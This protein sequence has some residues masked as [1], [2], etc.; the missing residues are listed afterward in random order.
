VLVRPIAR[1][2]SVQQYKVIS[3]LAH[4]HWVAVT[5]YPPRS[6]AKAIFMSIGQRLD[7]A[8]FTIA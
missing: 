6:T 1:L 5:D 8:A 2:M 3:F 4:L 7:H